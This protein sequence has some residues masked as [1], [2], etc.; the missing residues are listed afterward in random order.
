MTMFFPQMSKANANM[1]REFYFYSGTYMSWKTHMFIFLP[2]AT[3]SFTAADN[4]LSCL[5]A[6]CLAASAF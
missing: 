6:E 3:S 5:V 2:L 4:T 1:H